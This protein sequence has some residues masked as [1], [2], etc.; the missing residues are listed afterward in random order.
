[1]QPEHDTTV[2]TGRKKELPIAAH[3]A[4][5]ERKCCRTSG[6]MIGPRARVVFISGATGC[7]KTTQVPLYI[8]LRDP[9]NHK[10]LVV[11][12]RRVAA[13]RCA[14]RVAEELSELVRNS[15]E[16]DQYGTTVGY[17]IG[18]ERWWR[19]WDRGKI[20]FVTTSHFLEELATGFARGD[21]SPAENSKPGFAPYMPYTHI[22]L[23]EVHELSEDLEMLFLYVKVIRVLRPAIQIILMSAT[24]NTKRLS[25][26]SLGK[27]QALARELEGGLAKM[28]GTQ[29]VEVVPLHSETAG[30]ALANSFKGDADAAVGHG[31]SDFRP[32]SRNGTASQAETADKGK[33]EEAEGA[34]ADLTTTTVLIRTDRQQ[35]AFINGL[36][37]ANHDYGQ[38]LKFKHRDFRWQ[39]DMRQNNENSIRFCRELDTVVGL[40]QFERVRNGIAGDVAA[41]DV[42]QAGPV[43]SVAVADSLFGSG[44][45]GLRAPF[46]LTISRKAEARA[47]RMTTLVGREEPPSMPVHHVGVAEHRQPR[48]IEQHRV[49]LAT[50]VAETSL[51]L[52]DVAVVIDAGLTRRSVFD[53]ETGLT[54]LQA[55]WTS[56]CSA[57]QRRGRTGRTCAG[58]CYRLYP[59]ELYKE[60][61]PDE[62][63]PYYEAL[64]DPRFLLRL[65][66][67][68]DWYLRQTAAHLST[69]RQRSGGRGGVSRRGVGSTSAQSGP[70]ATTSGSGGAHITTAKFAQKVARMAGELISKPRPCDVLQHLDFFQSVGVI[71]RSAPTNTSTGDYHPTLLGRLCLEVPLKFR[72]VRLLWAAVEHQM[73]VEGV[74]LASLADV[75]DESWGGLAGWSWPG[76]RARKG[77]ERT[78][79]KGSR[80][81]REART[82]A[83]EGNADETSDLQPLLEH[84]KQALADFGCGS[85]ASRFGHAPFYTAAKFRTASAGAVKTTLSP[86]MLNEHAGFESSLIMTVDSVAQQ[87]GGSEQ[88][89]RASTTTNSTFSDSSTMEARFLQEIHGSHHVGSSSPHHI[90]NAAGAADRGMVVR[91]NPKRYLVP[92]FL[93]PTERIRQLRRERLLPPAMRGGTTFW[94]RPPPAASTGALAASLKT[95]QALCE[96]VTSSEAGERC[97]DAVGGISEVNDILYE[98]ELLAPANLKTPTATRG[99]YDQLELLNLRPPINLDPRTLAALDIRPHWRRADAFV[100][101]RTPTSAAAGA[102]SG[103]VASTDKTVPAAVLGAGVFAST[104]EP[105]PRPARPPLPFVQRCL[106]QFAENS[107]ARARN[108]DLVGQAAVPGSGRRGFGEAKPFPAQL[109]EYDANTFLEEARTRLKNPD[110][111]GDSSLEEFLSRNATGRGQDLAEDNVANCVQAVVAD[112][113]V[114]EVAVLYMEQ[115][116]ANELD[117]RFI[118]HSADKGAEKK[119]MLQSFIS[120]SADKGAEEKKMLQ[121]FISHSADKGAEKKKMLQSGGVVVARTSSTCS[122]AGINEQPLNA[123]EASLHRRGL[124]AAITVGMR[125]ENGGGRDPRLQMSQQQSA[126][127]AKWKGS[128]QQQQSPFLNALARHRVVLLHGKTGSGKSTLAPLILAQHQIA[129]LG[130]SCRI[131]VTQPRRDSAR[132][133]MRRINTVCGLDLCRMNHGKLLPSDKVLNPLVASY[134]IA[135]ENFDA[136]NTTASTLTAPI[137]FYTV[138]TLKQLLLRSP[139]KLAEYSHIVLDEIHERSWDLDFLCFLLRGL[140]SRP[141]FCQTRVILMTATMSPAVERLAET[142]FRP[143][144]YGLRPALLGTAVPSEAEAEQESAMDTDAVVSVPGSHPFRIKEQH[145]EDFA[146][147]LDDVSLSRPVLGSKKF[148]TVADVLWAYLETFNQPAGYRLLSQDAVGGEHSSAVS[149]SRTG[150]VRCPSVA[151]LRATAKRIQT[152]S[153]DDAALRQASRQALQK[154]AEWSQST[155]PHLLVP[156]L[157]RL[158]S[159]MQSSARGPSPGGLKMIIFLPTLALLHR[160]ADVLR[161]ELGRTTRKRLD[162]SSGVPKI[163]ILLCHRDLPEENNKKRHE[164]QRP[165]EVTLILATNMCETG[166]TITDLDIV[167]DLGWQLRPV[168][169]PKL[170]SEAAVVGWAAATQMDQRRGRVGRTREG[171]CFRFYPRMLRERLLA[172]GGGDADLEDMDL[173]RVLLELEQ[174]RRQCWEQRADEEYAGKC[175]LEGD[176]ED[177][178]VVRRDEDA[179]IV[180]VVHD[181]TPEEEEDDG[182]QKTLERE[183]HQQQQLSVLEP[184]HQRSS[185]SHSIRLTACWSEKT[186]EW[187]HT[188]LDLEG[189]ESD[190]VTRSV[191]SDFS[192]LLNMLPSP[193][194]TK[195]GWGLPAVLLQL[196]RMGFL[197]NNAAEN[198]NLSPCRTGQNLA[199]V[200]PPPQKILAPQTTLLGFVA[201]HLGGGMPLCCAA[202][203]FMG[204][205]LDPDCEDLLADSLLLAASTAG[206]Q[207]FLLTAQTLPT[208]STT[209]ASFSTHLSDSAEMKKLPTMSRE[210]VRFHRSLDYR[211]NSL[212]RGSFSEPLST[213]EA[214]RRRSRL[215]AN[216]GPTTPAHSTMIDRNKFDVFQRSF[217]RVTRNMETIGA[218]PEPRFVGDEEVATSAKAASCAGGDQRLTC[219]ASTAERARKFLLAAGMA[220]TGGPVVYA[221][222]TSRT[223]ARERPQSV[224][225]NSFLAA[226]KKAEVR[227]Y[228]AALKKN[229]FLKGIVVKDIF[230]DGDEDEDDDEQ[231]L[232]ASPLDAEG[233]NGGRKKFY[234]KT[235]PEDGLGGNSNSSTTFATG[236]M[237][238]VE[239]EKKQSPDLRA[240]TRGQSVP[241]PSIA[242]TLARLPQLLAYAPEMAV[243]DGAKT[244]NY[245]GGKV[246]PLLPM[247]TW[248]PG[249][250][251]GGFAAPSN[252]STSTSEGG[253][254]RTTSSL[255]SVAVGRSL[256][257]DGPWKVR[258]VDATLLPHSEAWLWLLAAGHFGERVELVVQPRSE[259]PLTICEGGSHY[260]FDILGLRAHG[261]F[262]WFGCA[263]GPEELQAVRRFRA[264]FQTLLDTAETSP[265]S[266]VDWDEEEPTA[267]PPPKVLPE[268]PHSRRVR[269][270]LRAIVFRSFL[271]NAGRKESSNPSEL[272]PRRQPGKTRN[273]SSTS[274]KKDEEAKKEY[275]YRYPFA[276]LF[277]VSLLST[278]RC[279]GRDQDAAIYEFVSEARSPHQADF[280]NKYDVGYGKIGD[281]VQ[282]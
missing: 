145:L 188:W 34:P 213:F 250:H 204:W 266:S 212:D 26:A 91:A 220:M 63:T 94:C 122:C 134:H 84:L 74:L 180:N 113:Q 272:E 107:V 237:S 246:S 156:V 240:S 35:A 87:H 233:N 58:V 179:A 280:L 242:E 257:E 114:D 148:A 89:Q 24:A 184:Q 263:F 177:P 247:W 265:G 191:E 222:T 172:V 64:G 139:E 22:I 203:V 230:A 49:F 192:R 178:P 99:L 52:P 170:N 228:V 155:F 217:A 104:I 90:H 262:F 199:A 276:T 267:P 138:G 45:A 133:C 144:R 33:A 268:T 93:S 232:G 271:N 253:V 146:G 15:D 152:Q 259:E 38:E 197:K 126:K 166:E 205:A 79:T 82:P 215:G 185:A 281:D 67:M 198:L 105:R 23:D 61:M 57:D 183:D 51:T 141:Q 73:A 21:P 282:E 244:F 62:E 5:V 168:Y 30:A 110:D 132:Q 69:T 275:H 200:E 72:S 131:A 92:W 252:T 106:K 108:L 27:E 100:G 88:E 18:G 227:E 194:K 40:Q 12:P 1:M 97:S 103:T 231:V 3:R 81:S 260:D 153:C 223:S 10:I 218:K 258:V 42:I 158:M 120:H 181:S 8:H 202:I 241:L 75:A 44:W 167:I 39:A 196:Q 116:R 7:G 254:A 102:G 239:E 98:V 264:L 171:L 169:N 274:G 248:Y 206:E 249:R 9:D 25:S 229:S 47:A 151:E 182:E 165:G 137:C 19:G 129:D 13:K 86:V 80:R 251:Y 111:R 140:L 235:E 245:R 236:E 187:R 78:K 238:E 112:E 175:V 256:M 157:Q 159:L 234:L 201:M 48:A 130:R 119:K 109:D 278:G 210:L 219:G 6:N 190:V 214:Y 154:L 71:D 128:A 14:M 66:E 221:S 46:R 173:R 243:T 32:G 135:G 147:F 11:Q 56:K 174:G 16:D 77:N 149:G 270:E 163:T 50:N 55:S 117:R 255:T 161:L 211:Y 43:M 279:D 121:S 164:P 68:H 225:F 160:C 115:T 208:S 277:S 261:R 83:A 162:E 118:S 207:D 20:C 226:S 85:F 124:L 127:T 96:G 65:A 101:L 136:A 142:T 36:D 216:L 2:G 37:F 54:A 195:R 31:S 189:D 193:P 125:N 150:K 53:P 186:G 76:T 60:I 143:L 17:R 176:G 41:G 269:R 28:K 209:L 273:C 224:V 4:E 29:Q 95:L 123:A 59:E 70:L